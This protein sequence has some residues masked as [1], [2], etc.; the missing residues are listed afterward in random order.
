[1]A[2]NIFDNSAKF[3]VDNIYKFLEDNK[4]L[5][6]GMDASI[7]RYEISKSLYESLNISIM[8]NITKL[9]DVYNLMINNFDD[10]SNKVTQI[11]NIIK[12]FNEKENNKYIVDPENILYIIFF[13][14]IL[15]VKKILENI[16]KYIGSNINLVFIYLYLILNLYDE[17]KISSNYIFIISQM[18]LSS[19][20]SIESEYDN[21]I[22]ELL[23]TEVI[24][25][26]SVMIK[27]IYN[28]DPDFSKLLED[29]KIQKMEEYKKNN[30][31]DLSDSFK[32][33]E[34]SVKSLNGGSVNIY[35]FEEKFQKKKVYLLSQK[36]EVILTNLYSSDNLDIILSKPLT[37]ELW[38]GYN[39]FIYKR[40][41]FDFKEYQTNI[42][43][44][45]K[46]KGFDQ[47]YILNL[48][49]LNDIDAPYA[50]M[51]LPVMIGSGKYIN[52]N[53]KNINDK[54][55]T[56]YIKYKN[57]YLLLRK[58]LNFN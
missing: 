20:S 15:H 6:I 25:K 46:N 54:Y 39:L 32:E 48:N 55:Y 43:Q 45:L 26:I 13:K 4:E 12:Q 7:D 14:Q 27:I 51:M 30:S 9:S 50:G 42:N 17:P 11:E 10:V 47:I 8:G 1:M 16:N 38:F 53:L 31:V 36:R 56:K 40:F 2:Q 21:R 22:K 23:K 3:S 35:D 58:K 5:M 29:L 18:M 44:I 41:N 33:I 34:K 28:S 57:K 24:E 52:N 37:P 49:Y 19:S